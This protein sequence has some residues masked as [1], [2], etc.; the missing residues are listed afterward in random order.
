ML[1]K[2]TFKTEKWGFDEV[3]PLEHKLYNYERRKVLV[4]SE[5]WEK[6]M[7]RMRHLME[8]KHGIV[9]YYDKRM[10]CSYYLKD[11]QDGD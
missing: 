6:Y 11:R 7:G 9:P 4:P 8:C 5:G 1:P 2:D 10:D 3:S